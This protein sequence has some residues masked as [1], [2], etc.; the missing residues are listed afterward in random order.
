M[1]LGLRNSRNPRTWVASV[2]LAS[3]GRST[4]RTG[5]SRVSATCQALAFVVVP[6]TPS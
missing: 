2:R 4:S 3:L 1:W 6:P 5:R